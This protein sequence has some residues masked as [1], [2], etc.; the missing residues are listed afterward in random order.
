[1]AVTHS[2]L[3]I[4]QV[5]HGFFT[6]NAGA[7][8]LG[9]RNCA[10]RV[11]DDE[12]EVDQNRARCAE[13]VGSDLAHLVTV[14]QRHTADVVIA[15]APINWRDAPIAD[16]LVTTTPGLA[17]G[18]LTADCVPVLFA[19]KDGKVIGAAHAGWRGAFDGVLQ[20]TVAT[21]ESL[22]ATRSDIV[23]AVGPCIGQASYEVGPEFIARFIEKDKAYA[24]YFSKPD[25]KG[26]AHFDLARFAADRLKQANVGTVVVTGNDT[27]AEEEQFFSFRRA[28]L[29]K[30]PDY[31]RQ[32]SV[33]SISK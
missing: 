16:A 22:G 10:Y 27:C 9:H 6:R 14:K 3:H 24:D 20:N 33:I 26:H 17:L 28:T 8:V 30:E 4:A 15:T 11:G 1:M 7:E 2:A 31:G 21:M 23:A 25:N 32:M 29:R 19:S 18:I 5:R 13:G 12:T